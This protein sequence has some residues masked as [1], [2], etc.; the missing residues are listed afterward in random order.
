MLVFNLNLPLIHYIKHNIVDINHVIH[1]AGEIFL[2]TLYNF[3]NGFWGWWHVK[4][5]VETNLASFY[6]VTDV[7]WGKISI[8]LNDYLS[9]ISVWVYL[10]TYVYTVCGFLSFPF[11]VETIFM[12]PE[13]FSMKRPGL[14]SETRDGICHFVP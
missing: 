7:I 14:S 2:F 6:Q 3:V 8:N 5:L 9:S 4:Q 11:G 1:S 13:V 12:K 10:L